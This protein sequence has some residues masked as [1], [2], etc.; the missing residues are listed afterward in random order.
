[1]I[2]RRSALASR[3]ENDSSD[4]INPLET[5]AN[6]TDVMLVFAVALM[7]A[8]VARWGM[9]IGGA[10]Q[11]DQSNLSPVESDVTPSEIENSSNGRSYEEVGKVYRDTETGELYV[12]EE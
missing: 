9:D 11:I 6:I 2:R 7:V 3:K 8:L 10:I 12:L 4:S 5:M 1:V